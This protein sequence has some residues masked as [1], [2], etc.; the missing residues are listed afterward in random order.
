MVEKIKRISKSFCPT[1]VTSNC[2]WHVM[3][4]EKLQTF[5][6]G[7]LWMARIDEFADRLEGTLPSENR[8]GLLSKLPEEQILAVLREYNFAV[9]R[10]YA[11]CWHMSDGGPSNAIW[12]LG[13]VG[14]MTTPQIMK[15]ALEPVSGDEGPV[16]F[17]Q[18]RYIDHSHETIPEGNTLEA[19]F[20]VKKKYEQ[21]KEARVLIHTYGASAHKYLYG[22]KGPFGD[23][24]QMQK[25]SCSISGKHEFIGGHKGGKAIVLKIEPMSFIEAIV[26]H[27]SA[28]DETKQ[29]IIDLLNCAGLM[30]KLQK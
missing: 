3:S 25:P 11:S 4:S 28:S 19:G 27:P 14:L 23:L 15:K 16:Y 5:I 7:G 12:E 17:G 10:S 9:K 13:C 26:I 24:I 21:Q 18:I 20:V 29:Q 30:E 22:K 6:G 2:L 1:P 8:L